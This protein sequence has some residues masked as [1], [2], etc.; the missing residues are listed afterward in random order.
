MPGLAL[1]VLPH[2]V[3]K[4]DP[5]QVAELT[6][7]AFPDVVRLLEADAV[8]LAEERTAGTPSTGYSTSAAGPTGCRSF[9]PRPSVSSA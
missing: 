2:P 5:A 7:R 9:R 8:A 4:L 1:T 3:A 6:E